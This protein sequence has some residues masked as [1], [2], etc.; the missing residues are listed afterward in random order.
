M[1][2]VVY[3]QLTLS[4]QMIIIVMKTELEEV[5]MDL[6]KQFSQFFDKIIQV[7]TCTYVCVTANF[8]NN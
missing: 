7:R 2:M 3:L 6:E 8:S 4:F 1:K 5:R